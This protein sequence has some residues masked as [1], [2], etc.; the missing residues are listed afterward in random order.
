MQIDREN[1]TLI[2]KDDGLGMSEDEFQDKFLKIG[3]S[4]RKDGE[5]LSKKKRPFIGR[6]GIGKL[7]LLSC[8][9]KISISTKT[10]NSSYIGGVI[11]NSGL[12]NAIKDDLTPQ[13][14]LLEKL[15]KKILNKFEEKHQKGTI[16]YFEG[17]KGGIRNREEYL[18]K[19]I[20][21]YFRFSLLDASFNIYLNDKP[22][23]I[24]ELDELANNTQFVWKINEINDPYLSKKISEDN[25][26]KRVKKLSSEIK[27]KGFIASVMK[28]SN[29]TIRGTGEKT[30]IDLFVNGRLREKDILKHISPTSIVAS[31]LYGQIHFDDLDDDTDRF[32]SSR[33]GIISDDPEFKNFL[34]KMKSIIKTIP[35]DWDIWRNELN[36][37]GDTENK[38]ITRKERKS[39]ELFNAISRD[40]IPP[41]KARNKE[42]VATW[43]NNLGDDAQFNFASYGE[44][45]I[46]ENL[47]RN[48]INDRRLRLSSK[49]EKDI[50]K[51][52]EKEAENKNKANISIE[53]RRNRNSDLSYLSMDGLANL[54]EKVDPITEAGLSR[55]A[56]EYKP[57][58]DALAHTALL[59]ESAKNRLNA[60]Y[61]NIKERVK[62]LID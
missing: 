41:K 47:L 20:A 40:F 6:K 35:M 53:L 33:E 19:L 26:V 36:Q 60:T 54:I 44:C 21:L 18:R 28:P 31:Y 56:K 46:A 34:E 38:R 3:Y 39:R 43:V 25:N 37:D 23:E 8:A 50:E 42:K 12:D 24:D 45:F 17:I 52:K 4:K 5:T 14:Y 59:T 29:L 57:I 49:A 58:R 16:I 11:D 22:I 15:N 7:A 13:E 1:S 30:S 48:Y 27:I 10:E 9:E 61:D 51:Y 32:T 62:T 55:D 2:I